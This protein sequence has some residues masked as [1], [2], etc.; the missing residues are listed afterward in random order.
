MKSGQLCF[1]HNPAAEFDDLL[2]QLFYGQL[3]L[4]RANVRLSVIK[5][6]FGRA[7][8]DKLQQNLSLTAVLCTR[9][10]FSVG[11][12]SRAAFSELYV[13]RGVE[14]SVRPEFINVSGSAVHVLAT[15]YHNRIRSALSENQRGEQS[16]GSHSDHKGR[17]AAFPFRNVVCIWLNL[18]RVFR[19]FQY[20]VL[21]YIQNHVDRAEKE[22][23]ILFPCVNRAA[24]NAHALYRAVINPQLATDSLSD[25]RVVIIKGDMYV[26]NSYHS[27]SP[28]IMPLIK[29]KCR[30]NP[31]H[32]P[33]MSTASPQT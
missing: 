7:V 20:V 2:T 21:I 32:S 3:Q 13:R 4:V 9:V 11:K 28:T 12:C 6:F 10:Q 26:V 18:R 27:C 23:I 31:P 17:S 25:C 5:D 19:L 16:R 1:K 33:H 30:L 24:E 15:F 8:T 14:R 29:A 22:N